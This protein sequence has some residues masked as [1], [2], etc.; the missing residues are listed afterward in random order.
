[1]QIDKHAVVTL[2]YKLSNHTTGEK[3]EETT[4][5]NPMVFLFGAG[6][7]I[8]EFEQNVSG[9]NVGDPFEFTIAAANAYGVPS[10]DNIVNI[11]LD[12]FKNEE[13]VIDTNEIKVG[14]I[15]PM[16]DDQGNMMRGTILNISESEV[17]MDFNHPLAGTDLHFTGKIDEV[18]EATKDEID[19]GHVHG[20][21]GHHH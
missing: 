10:D 17:R 6:Q 2:S 18:R 14:A 8:P 4:A 20:P 19:H 7:L 1:M 16:S 11:P 13:G 15:L 5:E 12:V 3:I 9:L 21:H